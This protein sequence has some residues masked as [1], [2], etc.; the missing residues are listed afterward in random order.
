[1]SPD[2]VRGTGNRHPV[3][4]VERGKERGWEENCLGDEL[5]HYEGNASCTYATLGYA[6][7]HKHVEFRHMRIC[8]DTANLQGN[9]SA[10]CWF[11]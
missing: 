1:M 6:T 5:P 11:R 2:A 9:A 3:E 4:T 8:V 10:L 7:T